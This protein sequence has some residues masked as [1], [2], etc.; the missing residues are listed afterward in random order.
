MLKKLRFQNFSIGWK[1]GVML[2]IIFLLFAASTTVVSMLI[3]NMGDHVE[4]LEQRGERTVDIMEMGSLIRGKSIRIVSYISYPDP[5]LIEEYE[6]RSVRFNELQ[7]EIAS[8]MSSDEQRELFNQVIKN[9]EEL[10]EMF[11]NTIV[12][13]VNDG[14]LTGANT[15]G[16]LENPHQPV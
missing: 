5:A 12:P 2:I 11:L 3:I 10:N 15:Y 7:S 1:Y 8:N 4:E 16:G 13:A 9:D 14:D 6:E